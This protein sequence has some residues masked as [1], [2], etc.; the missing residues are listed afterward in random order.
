MNATI[1][2]SVSSS[3]TAS[4]RIESELT[5]LNKRISDWDKFLKTANEIVTRAEC[6]TIPTPY[7]KSAR[8]AT[9][10]RFKTGSKLPHRII[11]RPKRQLK[12]W[13]FCGVF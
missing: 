8:G 5:T 11:L 13:S 4:A 12:S 7:L 3:L 6:T 2:D 9:I 1:K 10:P